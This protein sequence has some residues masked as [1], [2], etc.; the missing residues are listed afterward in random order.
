LVKPVTVNGDDVPVAVKLPGVEVAKYPVIGVGIPAKDGATKVT[1][2]AALLAVAE[3]LV[4]A[5]GP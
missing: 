5:P 3:T 4:G 1:V 2:A